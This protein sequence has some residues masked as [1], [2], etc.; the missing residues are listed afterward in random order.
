MQ[1]FMFTM[2]FESYQDFF[3]KRKSQITTVQTSCFF[4]F[5]LYTVVNIILPAQGISL[6]KPIIKSQ[7]RQRDTLLLQ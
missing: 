4:T 2:G 7:E 5:S 1:S 3:Q 6:Q